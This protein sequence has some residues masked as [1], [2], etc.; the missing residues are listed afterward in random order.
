MSE[1]CRDTVRSP[2]RGKSVRFGTRLAKLLTFLTLFVPPSS[3][4]PRVRFL[5]R[6]D[7]KAHPR[8]TLEYRLS[9]RLQEPVP[10]KI[11]WFT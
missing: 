2:A 10:R 11:I 4:H 6:D 5:L 9:R 3:C 1:H 8:L 7:Q